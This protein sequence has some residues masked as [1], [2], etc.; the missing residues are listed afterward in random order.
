M[1]KGYQE[2]V[3][4]MVEDAEDQGENDEKAEEAAG[5]CEEAKEA[6]EML[7]MQASEEH[8]VIDSIKQ[9]VDMFA[10]QAS[11]Y[12]EMAGKVFDEA[13]ALL[14]EAKL[15]SDVM[16]L[17]EIRDLVMELEE[18]AF[19]HIDNAFYLS[20]MAEHIPTT[21]EDLIGGMEMIMQEAAA[22]KTNASMA[23]DEAAKYTETEMQRHYE[24]VARAAYLKAKEHFAMI[25]GYLKDA[26]DMHKITEEQA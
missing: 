17:E 7:M 6:L 2:E 13:K 24:E 22:N 10:E 12:K 23:Y 9:E 19:E 14:E 18:Q 15:T 21:I 26:V 1:A 3:E 8:E 16:T 4:K 25:E 20:E 5:Q 11:G